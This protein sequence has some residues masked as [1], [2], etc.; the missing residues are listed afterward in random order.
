MSSAARPPPS[1]QLARKVRAC[2]RPISGRLAV[3]T[4]A[5]N[6]NGRVP[7]AFAA[8]PDKKV[9][10]RCGDVLHGGAAPCDHQD[11]ACERRSSLRVAVGLAQRSQRRLERGPG[12]KQCRHDRCVDWRREGWPPLCRVVRMHSWTCSG[13]CHVS[14]VVFGS[15]V[16]AVHRPVNGG[17]YQGTGCPGRALYACFWS[18]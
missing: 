1:R 15:R 3:E 16:L 6:Q 13:A 18:Y 14:C 10:H 11:D 7:T 17:K 5:S 12:R 2:C 9:E 4:G 8:E